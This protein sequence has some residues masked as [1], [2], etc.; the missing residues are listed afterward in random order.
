MEHSLNTELTQ[1]YLL[2]HA[3]QNTTY[4]QSILKK[5]IELQQLITDGKVDMHLVNQNLVEKLA[6]LDEIIVKEMQ[7]A[8]S[9][10]TTTKKP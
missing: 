9:Q 8:V 5:Q 3:I 1:L 4:L 2:K 6:Q 10:L 7:E